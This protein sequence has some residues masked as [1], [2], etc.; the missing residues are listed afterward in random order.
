MPL[1]DYKKRASSAVTEKSPV[2]NEK[3][4][5]NDKVNLTH[6]GKKRNWAFIVYPESAPE[7]WIELLGKTGLQVAIS[8][9][10]DRDINPDGTEKKTHWHVIVIYSGPTSYNV[11]RE[12]TEKLNAPNPQALE[13]VRGYFRYLTHKDNP[14]KVQYDEKDIKTLNGFS[15]LDFIELTRSEVLKVKKDLV[16]MIR[17]LSIIEYSDLL[18]HLQ[19]SG[20]ET[21]FEVACNN[22]MFLNTYISSR[23]HKAVPAGKVSDSI[24][25]LAKEANS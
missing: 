1:R 22:T 21:E 19:D 16:I 10:H 25:G 11:V 7:N 4:L 18:E 8:P 14:E 12:L 13:A 23:R 6:K 24:A 9:L 3:S 2:N 20:L 17:E 5:S 15:I